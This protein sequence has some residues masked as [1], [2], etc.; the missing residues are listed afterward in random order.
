ML[1]IQTIPKELQH[2]IVGLLS[3]KD[4]LRL[5]ETCH[6][7]KDVVRD[8]SLW[9]KLV[10]SYEEIKNNTKA[11]MDHV[12]RCSKLQELRIFMK[13]K[14]RIRSDKIMM[15][16]MKAK[17]TLTTL[18]IGDLALSDASLKKSQ[19]N[20]PAHRIRSNSSQDSKRWRKLR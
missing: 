2:H 6:G 19:P 17:T 1:S 11:C 15:V 20:E 4:R 12:A 10:L 7:L 3:I 9:K 8:P 5:S 16:V 13:Q 14:E 18:L